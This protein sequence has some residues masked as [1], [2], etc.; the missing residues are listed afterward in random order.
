MIG[1]IAVAA[2]AAVSRAGSRPFRFGLTPVFLN[3]DL[4]LLEGLQ[5]YLSRAMGREVALVL[6]RTYQEITT[7]LV[8]GQL[9]AAWICGYPFV[10]YRDRLRL[11]AV[12]VW[13][14]GTLYQSYLIAAGGRP[15]TGVDDLAGDVHAFSDPDS[16]SG[17]LVTSAPLAERGQRPEGFFNRAF[18]TY[19]H[20]NVVRAV[21]SRLAQSGSV[22][23][24]VWEVLNEVEPELTSRTQVVWRS[25]WMGFPP[26]ATSVA[27]EAL[28]ERGLRGIGDV[29]RTTLA[30]YRADRDDRPLTPSD[31][32]DLKLLIGAEAARKRLAIRWENGLADNAALPA[33]TVRQVLLNL[34]LNSVT[35]SPEEAGIAVSIT[36]TDARLV[37]VVS[38][39]GGGLPQEPNDPLHGRS[40]KPASSPDGVGLGLW[41]IWRLVDELNGQIE[42]KSA[43]DATSIAVTLPFP[44]APEL[45][46][47]A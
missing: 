10:A 22:D 2:S 17:F 19:G 13:R 43:G 11:V 23:G 32:D 15:A 25:G 42:A 26:V 16:N 12:P 40:S 18:F 31:L 9:E 36:A 45:R 29:V 41:M 6:R 14:R 8:S 34:M 21:A 37:L 33:S 4:A 27:N 47:A 5:H 24:Y 35:A 1:G 39:R 44:P 3:S 46:H 20:R 28:P 30:T 7:E 38:D